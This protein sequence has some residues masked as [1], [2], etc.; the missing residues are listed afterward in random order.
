MRKCSFILVF[1]FFVI[2]FFAFVLLT[3]CSNAQKSYDNG[4]YEATLRA[5]KWKRTLDANDY[6]L[7]AN[8]LLALNRKD[9]ALKSFM[10]FL[11][12]S[13][14]SDLQRQ[15]AVKNFISLNTYDSL[16]V[17]LLTS[18]DGFDA[19]VA[20]YKAYSNLG[21][22]EKATELLSLLSSQ[23][24]DL[25][26]VSLALEAPIGGTNIAK[27]FSSWYERIQEGDK[28]VF[29]DLLC[30]YL[31]SSNVEEEAAKICLEITDS[32]ITDEFYTSDNV[33]LSKLLKTKG[34]ILDK[35]YDRINARIYWTQAYKLNPN[36]TSLEDRLK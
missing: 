24:S 14:D 18:N 4:D 35:L 19:R 10:L 36:D 31:E 16:T 28:E 27:L 9:E 29:L 5:L 11:L 15:Y 32:L 17:F 12:L 2:F 21:N 33:L 7:Q 23:M 8:S 6:F 20:L 3:S 13:N 34:N 25:Q 26:L 1:L 30:S 22:V